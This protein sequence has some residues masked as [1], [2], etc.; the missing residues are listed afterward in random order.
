MDAIKDIEKR[1]HT[2]L[3]SGFF[4]NLSHQSLGQRF[5]QFHR[6]ARQTPFTHKWRLGAA[7]QKDALKTHDNGSDTHHRSLGEPTR[8]TP[9]TLSTT[10]FFR[11]PSNS[12]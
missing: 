4:R 10:R 2:D 7:H 1:P 3:H 9:I 11:W 8:H 5:A 6:P 12:A